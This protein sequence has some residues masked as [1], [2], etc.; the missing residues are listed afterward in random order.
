VPTNER[1]IGNFPL[2]GMMTKEHRQLLGMDNR[3]K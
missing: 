1:T 3:E 2:G